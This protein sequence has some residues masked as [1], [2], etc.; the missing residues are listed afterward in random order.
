MSEHDAL[1]HKSLRLVTRKNPDWHE[2]A[3]ACVCFANGRGGVLEI[4]VEDEETEPPV[5]QAIPPGLA[6]RV[7]QRI[8][9][10]TL[11]VSPAFPETR[12]APNGGEV[13]VVHVPT[14]SALACTT[15][16][17]Y[18]ARLAD[19][20][21][22]VPPEDMVRLVTEKGAL[23]WELA[24]TDAP[25]SEAEPRH[26]QRLLDGL[27]ASD[28]VKGTVKV[29]TDIEILS[30]Y[31]LVRDDRL[32]NLGVLWLGRRDQRARLRHAPIIQYL[33]YDGQR[34][35]VSKEMFGDDYDLTP[36]DQV[37]AVQALPVWQESIEVPQGVFR[38]QVPI[39]DIE[40][41]RELVANALVHRVYP[42]S[43]DIFVSLHADHLEIHSP[44]RLPVGVTPQ[45]ILHVRKR[46]NAGM[47]RLFHDL[48]LM[49]GEGTGYDR[50]YDLLLSSGRP[51]PDVR[52]GPD[53]V[54]VSV[55]GLDLDLRALKVI[56]AASAYG[57]LQERER[58]T[59]GLLAR[60]GPLT[61]AVLAS[62][63][64]MGSARDVEPWVGSLIDRKLVG[65]VGKARG[66]RL[67][68]NPR[69]LHRSGARART[70]LIDIEDYRL[71]ELIRTDIE[72]FPGSP[73]REIHERVGV[74]ISRRKIQRQLVALREDGHIRMEGER[75]GA[76][77]FP[78]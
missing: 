57:P 73:V 56:A 10:T 59:L 75:A 48:H 62:E 76:R 55:H 24:L 7:F 3:R 78:P 12:V 4:G 41:V 34:R 33:R 39:Y 8:A 77:Y 40:I 46:R 71:R 14:S 70:T 5:G 43:G 20:C 72:R 53:R 49:E 64:S 11:N 13:L 47:V 69:L 52:E 44:G 38:A 67:R 18:Y 16:G 60:K 25:A 68:V 35:K 74:E 29:R 31:D 54:E 61:R 23:V 58:I 2:I 21:A 63:L 22:P 1:E 6:D 32:T 42:T 28:R 50:M 37:E 26:V 15:D 66:Q 9:Q 27:R 65:T 45:N 17:R 19:A 30:S 51:A 36:W